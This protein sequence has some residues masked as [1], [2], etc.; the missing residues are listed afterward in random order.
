MA[1]TNRT[2]AARLLEPVIIVKVLI[3]QLAIYIV[4]NNDRERQ[5][6]RER[7]GERASERETERDRE[8]ETE[9][10]R[11]LARQIDR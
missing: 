3:T 6:E 11:Q 9:T 10:Q 2:L 5:G 7:K 1:E 8:R 4:V